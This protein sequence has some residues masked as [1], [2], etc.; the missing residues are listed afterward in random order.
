MSRFLIQDEMDPFTRKM[1]KRKT[2]VDGETLP[3]TL[4]YKIPIEQV[5]G[6]SAERTT[7]LK[8]NN[9]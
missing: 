7:P 5:N 6:L 9:L 3:S 1:V 2:K 4:I 8:M